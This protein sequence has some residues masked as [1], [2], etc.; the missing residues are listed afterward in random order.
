MIERD[1]RILSEPD[2]EDLRTTYG[3]LKNIY[4]E[5]YAWPAPEIEHGIGRGGGRRMRTYVR[6]WINEWDLRSLYPDSQPDIEETE[7]KISYEEDTALEWQ[8]QE[9]SDDP[10]SEDPSR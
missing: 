4:T 9:G 7:F 8:S 5:G 10:L 6:R 3:H 2:D 1:E